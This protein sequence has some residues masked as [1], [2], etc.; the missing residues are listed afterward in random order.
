M[1]S[2]AIIHLL[3][4]SICQISC[5]FFYWA[6]CFWIM[7][8]GSPFY[9]E[10]K[11]FITHIIWKWFLPVY[12]L[13]FHYLSTIFFFWGVQVL[14]F[15]ELQPINLFVHGL[16]FW[17]IYK[18]FANPKSQRFFFALLYVVLGLHLDIWPIFVNFCIWCEVQ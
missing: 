3:F 18:I 4:W 14:K 7:Q 12:A 2:F 5:H 9:T 6:V 17:C 16:S 8:F 1:C 10:Y 15:D 11:S 13:L